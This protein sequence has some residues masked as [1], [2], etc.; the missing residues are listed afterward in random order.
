MSPRL[1]YRKSSKICFVLP[2]DRTGTNGLW[3][4]EVNFL[5]RRWFNE[6]VR[7]ISVREGLELVQCDRLAGVF[8]NSSCSREAEG[9]DD[10]SAPSAYKH[11][12][13]V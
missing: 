3:L 12:Y 6:V 7:L 10:F 9:R 5:T 11:L 1:S 8:Q 4:Q 2:K 13:S